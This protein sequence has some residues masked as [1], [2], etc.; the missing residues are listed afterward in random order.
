MTP[1]DRAVADIKIAQRVGLASRE[2]F[3]LKYPGQ[4]EHCLRLTAERLQKGL[5]KNAM[6]QLDTVEV[7]D[8]AQALGHLHTI[9]RDLGQ[10]SIAVV[11]A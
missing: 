7:A 3:R 9:Y 11:P 5:D 4:I 2:A 8:L 6:R 1:Q 10:P